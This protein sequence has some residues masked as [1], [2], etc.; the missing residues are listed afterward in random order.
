[1]PTAIRAALACE[2]DNAPETKEVKLERLG[3]LDGLRAVAATAVVGF[4][5][6]LPGLEGGFIGV[7]VFFVLSGYLITSLLVAEIDR[8]G[9]V[10]FR[11]FWWRRAVRLLPA[12]LLMLAGVALVAPLFFPDANVL[13]ELL[14]SGFYLSNI[15]QPLLG[16]PNVTGHTWSLATELQFYLLWPAVVL[17]TA[18]FARRQMTAIFVAL[19]ITATLWRWLQY[20]DAGWVRAYYAPDTRLSGLMLGA[21]L[22]T[23]KWRPSRQGVDLVAAGALL[24]LA[25][26]AT[27]PGFYFEPISTWGGTVLEIA[28]FLLIAALRTGEGHIGRLLASPMLVQF[29]VW[30]YGL[31]LWHYPIAVVTRVHF[32]PWIAFGLTLGLSVA[33]AAIS[34]ALVEQPATR[35]FVRRRPALG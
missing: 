16:L 8:S 4:H 11:R 10:A 3:A 1:L 5:V 7:D 12:L 19:F 14:L 2:P 9:T 25:I 35:L 34:H 23:V 13:A 29:G 26:I 30:S 24:I 27:R 31:Y 21:V 28:T 32:D 6:R 15:S 20:W 17:L 22:A 33:L 18:K